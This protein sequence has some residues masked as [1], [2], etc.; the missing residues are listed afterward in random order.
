MR[1]V[2]IGAV[3][4]AICL[5][6]C[7]SNEIGASRDVAQ[8][9]I[10]MQFDMELSEPRRT[11]DLTAQFRFSGKD[12]T[13]LVLSAPSRFVM[14]G[15]TLSVDS[16][17]SAGAFYRKSLTPDMWWRKHD[18][19]FE[20]TQGKAY[21]NSITLDRSYVEAAPAAVSRQAPVTLRLND[22]PYGPDDEWDVYSV[23][24]DSSFSLT[25]SLGRTG[26]PPFQ[27]PAKELQRQKGKSLTL[28][29]QLTR[30]FQL[31]NTPAEGGRLRLRYTMLPL[32]M[33]LQ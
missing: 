11:G 33:A 20:D 9:R 2:L 1:N 15:E 30:Y 23:D 3:L 12:G 13:T 25:F 4:T 19:L 27:I 6:G 29:F 7:A 28:G 16:L 32:T 24:T 17:P 10:Y 26:Q 31:P 18:W 22:L 8:E 21:A 14:N 5:A